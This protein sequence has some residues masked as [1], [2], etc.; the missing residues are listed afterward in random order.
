MEKK[1]KVTARENLL[2]AEYYLTRMKLARIDKEIKQVDI[3][4]RK[5]EDPE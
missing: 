4:L 2:I 5:V 1:I 3:E